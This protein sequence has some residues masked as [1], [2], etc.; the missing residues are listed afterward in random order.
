MNGTL[1]CISQKCANHLNA[2]WLSGASL[3][4]L[5]WMCRDSLVSNIYIIKDG[6]ATVPARHEIPWFVLL[7]LGAHSRKHIF[8]EKKLPPFS[9]FRRAAQNMYNKLCWKWRFKDE[10]V[11]GNGFG[12]G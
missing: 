10:L 4:Q 3:L 2:K 12:M 6:V 11:D 1:A 7:S 8:G 5:G 9:L